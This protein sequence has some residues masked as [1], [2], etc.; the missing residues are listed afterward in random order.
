VVG[1]ADAVIWHD[2]ECG[3][4][5]ADLP[6]WRELAAA[7][8]GPLLE[9]GCGTGRV[10]LELA[11]AGH[12]VAAIDSEAALVSALRERARE[13]GVAVAAAVADARTFALDRRDLALAIAPMQV[14]QLMGGRAGRAA[15]LARV[16]EHLRPDGVLAAALA[17]PFE[18]LPAEDAGPPL[19]DVREQDG[20]VFS[21]TPVAVR[22]EAHGTAIDR[23]RQAVSPRGEIEESM[24]SI[25]LDVLGA[26][27]LESEGAAAGFRARPRRTVP[28]TGDYVGSVVV[29]LERA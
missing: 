2:V 27:E 24:T 8:G 10:A 1:L 21:S 23:H 22:A 28:S 13:R 26:D 12:D 6:L 25:V 20:W 18:G 19:P 5:A 29:V 9:L 15:M 4:Y 16:R 17:D 7:A 3:G 14:A 11:D